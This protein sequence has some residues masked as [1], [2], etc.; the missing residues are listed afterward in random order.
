MID[1]V[2]ITNIEDKIQV[3]RNQNV[4]IDSDVTK[5]YDVETKRIN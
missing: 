1:V 2:K 5:L 4:I 3:V